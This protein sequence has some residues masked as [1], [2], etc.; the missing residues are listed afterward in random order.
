[1]KELE[2][3]IRHSLPQ[4]LQQALLTSS[5][6]IERGV[7]EAAERS[8]RSAEVLRFQLEKTWTPDDN[9]SPEKIFEKSL[10]NER[11]VTPEI[12]ANQI[13]VW[14]GIRA[15]RG[16]SDGHCNIDIGYLIGEGRF[17]LCEL[18]IRPDDPLYALIEL[19]TYIYGYLI[20]RKLVT[21]LGPEEVEKVRQ[22]SRGLV[23]AVFLDWILVAPERFYKEASDEP[24]KQAKR[25]SHDELKQ[26]REVAERCVNGAAKEFG[27]KEL[28]MSL[29]LRYLKCAAPAT[30]FKDR[31]EGE[32]WIN[33]VKGA[34]SLR[35][36]ILKAPAF[37]N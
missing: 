13:P 34:T 11:E 19:V 18:K 30:S 27:F 22:R 33:E 37:S 25:L 14:S 24:K 29:S 26:V 8:L 16:R 6:S 3:E 2:R 31:S 32:R 9:K 7:Q 15:V 4:P 28:G 12:W 21:F 5:N 35:Q 23:D 10:A 36:L 20:A 1:M 17:A